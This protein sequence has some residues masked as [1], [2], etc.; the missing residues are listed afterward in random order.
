MSAAETLKWV[1]LALMLAQNAITPLIFR[2]ATTSADA[3]HRYNTSVAVFTSEAIKLFASF[4]L[5]GVE[6]NYSLSGAISTVNEQIIKKPKDTLKLAVPATLYFVQNV[7]LQLAS[8]NLPAALFQVTYQGKTLVVALFSV[9]LLQKELIRARWFAIFLM[10][11]GIATVQLSSSKE[12]AQKD[13][14]NSEE[15]SIVTG[16]IFVLLG[17]FCSGF[18]GVYFEMLMK[19]KASMWVRN[20]QLASFSLVIGLV[21]IIASGETPNTMYHGFDEAVWVMVLNN[22]AG[23]LCV[24]FVI[25]YADNILKGFACALATIVATLAS[26]PLFGFELTFSFFVGMIV[27]IGSTLLYGGTVKMS[28]NYWNS[29]PPLCK[30]IRGAPASADYEKVS[31][32][33]VPEESVN[34]A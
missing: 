13:M 18:A 24:A 14:A 22:A 12:G 16:L 29:E 1:S 10:A 4:V 32:S 26:V 3:A 30:G 9:F 2:Y 28:G 20:V 21:P 8:S 25:K 34:K 6:E 5:I 19:Q 7:L 11:A 15:Q 17:C 23:G 33:D 27:V 31:M